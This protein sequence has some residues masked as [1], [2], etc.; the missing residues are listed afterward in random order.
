V[1]SFP[2]LPGVV[3]ELRP[4]DELIRIGGHVVTDEEKGT[5][6]FT[7]LRD[8]LPQQPVLD[9]D[10][11]RDGQAMQVRGP[12]PFPPL[13]N[14][15]LPL[16]AA[17]DA[18]LEVGDIITAIDGTPIFAF[19]QLKQR[20]EA[21]EGAALKLT[22][23]RD[24]QESEFVLKPRRVDEPQ[25]EGGFKTEWRIGIAGGQLFEPERVAYGPLEAVKLA[26][27]RVWDIVAGVP[28]AVYAL[29]TA[30]IS[31]C[32]MAGPI[33]MAQ[34][35]GHAASQGGE[36]FI[37]FIAL[38]S[39]AVGL[40]NLFPIPVLDGGHLMF[41]AYEAVFRR[42]AP[43]PVYMAL[44]AVGLALILSLMVFTFG[45]DIFCWL[46]RKEVF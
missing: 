8:A 24:G 36:Q 12:Y 42:P 6:D 41:Y 46:V 27:L 17:A 9:Y 19:D 30:K 45:N 25:P 20:V 40:F 7:G 38:I 31:S 4:G 3:N 35:A 23:W 44:M 10:I 15:L 16:S 34:V 28:E 18:G 26:S 43:Q 33:T 2:P 39:T 13:V 37:A 22:V 29:V 14:D 21:A 5:S 32:N 11:R 1:G